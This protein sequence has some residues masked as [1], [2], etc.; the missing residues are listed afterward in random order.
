MNPRILVFILSALTALD[1]SASSECWTGGQ[2]AGEL[3]FAGAVEG[4]SFFGQ[5]ERFSVEVCRP[6]GADWTASE[7]T[8]QVETA[9]ADTRNRDRDET[10][11]GPEFFAVDEFPTARWHSTRVIE[12]GPGLAVE[13]ELAL[14]GFTAPQRVLIEISPDGEAIEVRGSAEILRLEFGV[15]QGEF[16]DPEF[17][18]NRV[19]LDFDL[20]L[21]AK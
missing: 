8:V 11:H 4:E 10:L 19:D 16:E 14:R 17:V 6:M 5:F 20:R 13:G 9:S 3:R 1:A 15:G 2:E 21:Q 12:Q 7:W 18:R